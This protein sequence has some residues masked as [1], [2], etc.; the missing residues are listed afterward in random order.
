[1]KISST[2]NYAQFTTDVTN[3]PITERDAPKLKLLKASMEKYGFLPFPILVKRSGERL[4]ILDGQHRF[5]VAQE[6]NL[7]VLWVETDRDD[8]IIS[9]TAAPQLP[10]NMHHYIA[11]FSAQ[12]DQ[13]YQKLQIFAK[14]SGLPL[15]KAASLLIGE[16]STSGNVNEMIRDGKFEVRDLH[17]ARRVTAIVSV[18]KRHVPWALHSLSIGAIS[19]FARVREFDDAQMIKKIETHPHLLRRCPTLEMFSEMYEEVYN[20]SARSRIPL[21]FLAKEEMAKRQKVGERRSEKCAANKAA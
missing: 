6:L 2:R 7:P 12:G 9:E 3:R 10:W 20:H 16:I 11:S 5:A 14:E 4:R 19:R 18:V 17:Y 1:M 15:Q 13:E 21:A 8:I